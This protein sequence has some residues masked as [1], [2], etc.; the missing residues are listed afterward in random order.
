[1]VCRPLPRSW[2]AD[3][4]RAASQ[5]RS[6][7]RH[8]AEIGQYRGGRDRTDR[9]TGLVGVGECAPSPRPPSVRRPR[10][11]STSSTSQSK[12]ICIYEGNPTRESGKYQAATC[13][14]GTPVSRCGQRRTSDVDP[15]GYAV[16][17]TAYRLNAGIRW[18]LIVLGTIDLTSS[19]AH[20]QHW[21]AEAGDGGS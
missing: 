14:A 16:S 20:G 18:D 12:W 7:G 5:I 15:L 3:N 4:L 11:G 2:R 10:R 8:H 6:G 17:A 21:A 1:M 9:R 19:G 13:R